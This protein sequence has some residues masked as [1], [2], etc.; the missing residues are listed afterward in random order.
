MQKAI[1]IN[2]AREKH[3]VQKLTKTLQKQGSQHEDTA[4]TGDL[5]IKHIDKKNLDNKTT[6]WSFA[7]AEIKDV[8]DKI[9]ELSNSNNDELGYETIITLM[10]VPMILQTRKPD[11][12]TADMEDLITKDERTRQN[13]VA[14]SDVTSGMIIIP[15]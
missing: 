10:L 13:L 14:I 3:Q 6:C 7:G 4:H 8:H 15:N 12:F 9:K 11:E 5:P 1:K 2:L